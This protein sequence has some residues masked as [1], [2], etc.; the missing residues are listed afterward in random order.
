MTALPPFAAV[1]AV[2][3]LF[4]LR[5]VALL[6]MTLWWPQQVAA[7]IKQI[8]KV[9]RHWHPKS[10]DNC[11][12]C[13]R[14][15]CPARADLVEITP[16]NTRRGRRGAKKQLS[17]EGVTCPNAKCIYFGCSVETIHAMVSCGV[18]GKTDTIRR[19]KCQACGKTVSERKFTPLYRLKTAPICIGLVMSLLANGLDPSATAHVFHHDHWTISRWLPRA[20]KHVAALHDLYFRRLQCAFLQLDE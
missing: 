10:A 20:G 6:L 13:S 19:W 12:E 14:W 8:G 5:W 17:S 3:M 11:P 9:R 18:R 1:V 16:W 15:T 2:V 4:V 7:K